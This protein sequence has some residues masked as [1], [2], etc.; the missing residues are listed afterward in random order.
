MLFIDKGVIMCTGSIG[1]KRVFSDLYKRGMSSYLVD[2]SRF[3]FLRELEL[4]RRNSGVYNGKW[5]G[6]GEVV[7]SISP[8]SGQII[9]EVATGNEA[10]YDACVS[11][12]QEAWQQWSELPAPRR[13]NIVQQIGDALRAKL[14]PLGKLVSLEMGESTREKYQ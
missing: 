9:A 10:D 2:D 5:F 7:T 8:A 3:S 14:L 4:N 6:S 13:G 11:A 1:M 12:S